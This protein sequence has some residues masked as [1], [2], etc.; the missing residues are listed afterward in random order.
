VVGTEGNFSLGVATLAPTHQTRD[1]SADAGRVLFIC[2]Y[3][4]CVLF[5]ISRASC[6]QIPA[7]ACYNWNALKIIFISRVSH[8]CAKVEWA[9]Y[10][11]S[12]KR[13]AR[14]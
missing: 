14:D 12:E 9:K 8:Y 4:V 6:G 1:N 2:V 13:R 10:A 7:S 5:C 11:N 3:F